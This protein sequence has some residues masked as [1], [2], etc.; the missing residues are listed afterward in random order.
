[1]YAW[2]FYGFTFIDKPFAFFKCRYGVM[3]NVLCM[4]EYAYTTLLRCLRSVTPW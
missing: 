1:M 3:C 2:F 4:V